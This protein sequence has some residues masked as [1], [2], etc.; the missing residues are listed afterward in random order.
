MTAAPGRITVDSGVSDV[1]APVGVVRRFIVLSILSVLVMAFAAILLG[2]PALAV[3]LAAGGLAAALIAFTVLL[4]RGHTHARLGAAN[5]V[6][7]LR[8]TIVGVLLSILLA[9]G[10]AAAVVIP[11]SI[12]ALSLDGVDGAL[13]RRQKL[14][15]RFGAAF[16][17]EVDSAFAL[18]LSILAALGPAGPAALLLG[19]PRYLFGVA[20]LALPWLNGPLPPRFSRKV[21]CVVQLIVLIALQMPFLEAWVALTLVGMT[22]G[23]LAWSFGLDIV[24][25]Y[26]SRV[27][28]VA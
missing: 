3:A 14:E 13:A 26:R 21:I 7:L 6:T 18:V 25:L 16:D 20:G 5:A 19:L 10:G 28:S 24:A 8:L 22:V 11:L 17:M 9:G 4:R 1:R 12:I 2:V 27:R 23:L 15:S